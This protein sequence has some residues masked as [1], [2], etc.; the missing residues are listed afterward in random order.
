MGTPPKGRLLV[1]VRNLIA[2]AIKITK[3]PSFGILASFTVKVA[4]MPS[5]DAGLK[6]SIKMLATYGAMDT[7]ISDS[8]MS[9]RWDVEWQVKEPVKMLSLWCLNQRKN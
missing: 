6:R 3:E 1:G 4:D 5:K 2:Y 7:R 8:S 9:G